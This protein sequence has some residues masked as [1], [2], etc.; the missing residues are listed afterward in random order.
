MV[1]KLLGCAVYFLGERWVG[2]RGGFGLV[3]GLYHLILLTSSFLHHEQGTKVQDTI[4]FSNFLITI[5]HVFFG[6]TFALLLCIFQD[7]SY[8]AEFLIE[9]GYT[10]S[11]KMG[12]FLPY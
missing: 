1:V 4:C 11:V 3:G 12:R 10:V 8:L 2:V 9:K 5:S 7:G 6:L